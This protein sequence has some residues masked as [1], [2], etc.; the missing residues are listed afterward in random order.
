M[1]IN[2]DPENCIAFLARVLESYG[3]AEVLTSPSDED[4]KEVLDTVK[5]IDLDPIV[6]DLTTLVVNAV[7]N[8]MHAMALRPADY[9]DMKELPS[10][11]LALITKALGT[12]E[13]KQL[14]ADS[15]QDKLK[16][17]G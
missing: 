17:R 14:F 6:R 9:A 10:S 12:S 8:T 16:S 7:A 3:T 15:F 4:R 11:M 13:G 1:S 5:L 2:K